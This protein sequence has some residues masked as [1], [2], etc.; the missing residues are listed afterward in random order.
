[1]EMFKNIISNLSIKL[2]FSQSVSKTEDW[3][4]FKTRK[5]YTLWNI[6]EGNVWVKI[7]NNE[8]IATS[9]DVILFYPNCKYQAYTDKNGC[10]FHYSRFTLEMGNSI[11]LMAGINLAGVIP[12]QFLENKSS[13]FVKKFCNLS[14]SPQHISLKQY[15]LFLS[16]LTEIIYIGTHYQY[17]HFFDSVITK[18]ESLFKQ[19]ADYIEAH[20]AENVPIKDIAEKF[21][22]SEKYFISG[23]KAAMGIPPKQY[24]IQCR[25]KLSAKLLG[26]NCYSIGEIALMTGYSDHYAFCKAF[27]KYYEESPTDFKKHFM[28]DMLL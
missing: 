9:G 13:I 4:E 28:S 19:M 10:K 3:N 15:S 20:C 17:P 5:G 18:K 6:L 8:F 27:K 12:K 11:D 16:F 23:F 14:T 22:L 2:Y 21:E 1:M 7:N 25:M 24:L 26:E